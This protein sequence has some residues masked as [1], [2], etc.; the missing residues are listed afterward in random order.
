[1]W[2]N[3]NLENTSEKIITVDL[4]GLGARPHERS[5]LCGAGLDFL[6]PLTPATLLEGGARL[7]Y[8]WEGMM[9]AARLGEY[10]G[11]DLNEMFWM[12]KDYIR[13]IAAARDR[14]L[15]TARVSSDPERGV[16][17]RTGGTREGAGNTTVGA[18]C[19]KAVYGPD[20]VADET[21][22]ICRLAACFADKEDVMGA[23][24]SM[25][26]FIAGLRARRPGLKDCL[27]LAESV[28]REWNYIM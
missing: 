19:L 21:E 3:A 17:V 13:C 18:V 12:V 8:S 11:T 23:R 20:A 10:G 2:D 7:L 14:L 22:K 16:F 15:D 24:A 25:E 9:P 5:A 28:Q 6:L 26:Q 4:D 1:M 27:K